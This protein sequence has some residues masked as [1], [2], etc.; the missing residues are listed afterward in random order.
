MSLGE[1]VAAMLSLRVDAGCEHLHK[2][3]EYTLFSSDPWCKLCGNRF[4]KLP[5]SS[6]CLVCFF[7]HARGW[8]DW[9]LR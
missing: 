3:T 5:Y 4:W 7:F 1:T 8:F 2:V 6:A 9:G